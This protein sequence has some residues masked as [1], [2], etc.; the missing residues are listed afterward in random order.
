MTMILWPQKGAAR[1][2]TTRT[3]LTTKNAKIA[4]KECVSG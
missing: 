2:G 4:E 3:E 1:P